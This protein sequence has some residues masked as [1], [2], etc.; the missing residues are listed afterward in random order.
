MLLL[1]EEE[2]IK[3]NNSNILTETTSYQYGGLGKHLQVTQTDKKLSNGNTLTSYVRYPKDYTTAWPDI[4][5]LK[6]NY[7][8]SYPIEQATVVFEPGK[9]DGKL[10]SQE[11]NVYRTDNTGL[12]AKK[13]IREDMYS[14]VVNSSVYQQVTL[15][16]YVMDNSFLLSP[17][18]LFGYDSKGNVATVATKENWN[19]VYVW[20]YQK[21]YPIAKIENATLVEVEAVLDKTAMENFSSLPFPSMDQVRTFLAPLYTDARLTKAI[22]NTYTYAPMVGMT[23]ATAPNKVTTYFEYNETGKLSVIKDMNK[24]IIKQIQYNYKVLPR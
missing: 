15:S 16:D 11:K 23:S 21:A 20:A 19:I 1:K 22:V 18:L 3:D 13:Y 4:Q 24:D 12:L 2:M 17:K 7:M 6:D 10:L 8:L 5:N 9:S 14:Q